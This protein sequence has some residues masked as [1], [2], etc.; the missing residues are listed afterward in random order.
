MSPL[1]TPS[2]PIAH[3]AHLKESYESIEIPLNAIQY[4]ENR[5]YLGEDLKVIGILMVMQRGFTKRC[6]FFCLWHNR[7]TVEH[8]VRKDWPTKAT[9]IS[10]NSNKALLVEHK[11]V[12]MPSLYIKLGSIKNFIK[13]LE[14]SKFIGFV[15]LCN[16]FPKISEAKLK[17]GIFVGPQYR[18][19]LKDL[20][21][22]KELTSIELRAWKAFK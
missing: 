14:K 2:V 8:Y 15:F 20:D 12:L 5:W 22:E 17:E 18:E 21:F 11:D 19:V 16:K 4:N 3:S 7:A 6:R 1:A 13:H 10:G 9:Y